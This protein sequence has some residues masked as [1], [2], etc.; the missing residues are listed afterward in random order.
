[1]NAFHATIVPSS[2]EKMNKAGLLPVLAVITKAL[3]KVLK[4]VPVGVPPG[5]PFGI[6]IVTS[7]SAALG[8]PVP[9]YSVATPPLLSEIQKGLPAVMPLGG[10]NEIPHGFFRFE[11]VLRAGTAP[12]E[13]RFVWT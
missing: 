4:T 10:R 12:S 3:L 9:S 8:A 13:T 1:M 5:L 7:G 2:V 11:S 6:G